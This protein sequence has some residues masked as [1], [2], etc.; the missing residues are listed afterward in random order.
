MQFAPVK[1]T[2]D[3]SLLDRLDIRLGTI[4]AIADVPGSRKLLCLTVD[5]G[6]FQRTILS[7][8][9]QERDDPQALLDVQTLFVVNLAPRKMAGMV[10]EGMLFDIGYADGELPA[11][12]V[13]ERAMPDG[14]RAG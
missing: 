7:G 1:D 9:K 11:L 6:G 10:S 12:M 13:P 4:T 5:F 14:C 3:F 2:I 8:M